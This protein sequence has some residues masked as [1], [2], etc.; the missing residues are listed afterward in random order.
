MPFLPALLQATNRQH[1]S[2][3]KMSSLRCHLIVWG[4]PKENV[5]LLRPQWFRLVSILLKT[6]CNSNVTQH[7]GLAKHSVPTMASAA[8]P[9]PNTTIGKAQAVLQH[10]PS[11]PDCLIL[12][13][14]RATR[15]N[16]IHGSLADFRPPLSPCIIWPRTQ[17]QVN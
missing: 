13:L 1:C 8:S 2:S 4:G 5:M 6:S 11:T 17:L 14:P 9:L 16:R 15:A 3:S 7:R 12:C 10:G